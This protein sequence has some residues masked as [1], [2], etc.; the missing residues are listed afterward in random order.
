MFV[1]ILEIFN[2]HSYRE[3]G[4]YPDQDAYKKQDLDLDLDLDP[5]LDL[6]LDLYVE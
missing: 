6:Q 2:D 5:D 4:L 1:L 3:K